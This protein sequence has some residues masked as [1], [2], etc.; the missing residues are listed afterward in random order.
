MNKEN[1]QNKQILNKVEVE[2]IRDLSDFCQKWV[3]IRRLTDNIE[4][5]EGELS[6]EEIEVVKWLVLLADRVC[7]SEEY[8]K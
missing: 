4:S 7:L 3:K 2:S 8:F 1:T 6:R 5:L